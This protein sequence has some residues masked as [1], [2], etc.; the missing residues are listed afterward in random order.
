MHAT[1]IPHWLDFPDADK[2]YVEQIYEQRESKVSP[3][4]RHGR[5]QI[6][7]G[8]A[9]DRWAVERGEVG[10]E[11]R[12]YLV[13]DEER[14]SSLVPD[15]AYYSFDR[16]PI[17]LPDDVRERP[18]IAPDIAVEIISPDDRPRMLARKVE[19]YLRHGS[20]V[21]IVVDPIG[22]TVAFHQR[23]GVA[24]TIPASGR[25]AVPSYTDLILDFDE[26]FRGL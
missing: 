26:I 6:R 13:I 20:I 2:P 23:A 22:R 25:I 18:R 5:A 17:D 1:T 3:K 15:V 19:L 7:V 9:L 16:L 11:L 12:C 24:T 14:P 10:T 4:W 8:A 21:V